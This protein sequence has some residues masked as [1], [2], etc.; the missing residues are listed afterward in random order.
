MNK[1]KMQRNQMK[2]KKQP[3]A[4]DM[5]PTAVVDIAQQQEVDPKKRKQLQTM[6]A[7]MTDMIYHQDS[8]SSIQSMLTKGDPG[9]TIPATVNTVFMKFE[10]M[11]KEKLGDMP[12]DMKL[13][14][15]VH[16]F[17]EIM[18]LAEAQ[19]VIPEDLPEAQIQPLLKNT[20]Q[21]YVQRGL[22][23]KT[24][25][26]IDLQKRIEPMLSQQERE[27][28]AHMADATGTPVDVTEGQMMNGMMQ[29][30]QAPLQVEN[31]NLKKQNQGMQSALQG[32]AGGQQG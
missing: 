12:L 11:T 24:I 14:G 28:G 17:S 27:V 6:Q 26:P 15:G 25:D 9:H 18:E 13:A 5:D 8:K 22:K 23:E 7:M 19:G 32:I 3:Q 31:A 21:Q 1:R 20:I 30:A 29:K 4:P 16:L 2:N 10:D